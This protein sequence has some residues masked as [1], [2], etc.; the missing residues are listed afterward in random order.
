[1]HED[2]RGCLINGG[3]AQAV[4]LHY[5]KQTLVIAYVKNSLL[6]PIHRQ[7]NE[8]TV[9]TVKYRVKPS[10]ITRYLH[11]QIS[12]FTGQFVYLKYLVTI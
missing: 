2:H 6:I 11:Y 7:Y 10:I 5:I 12:L 1:M 4:T 3:S 9:H 8:S